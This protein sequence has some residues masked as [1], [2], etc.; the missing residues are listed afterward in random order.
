MGR[1]DTVTFYNGPGQNIQAHASTTLFDSRVFETFIQRVPILLPLP[2][3]TM[4]QEVPGSSPSVFFT[5]ESTSWIG[6]T[7]HNDSNGR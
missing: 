4:E 2:F 3:A 6:K 7:P 1:G 5:V